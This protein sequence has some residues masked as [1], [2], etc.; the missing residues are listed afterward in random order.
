MVKQDQERHIPCSGKAISLDKNMILVKFKMMMVRLELYPDPFI[1][2]L[3]LWT[4]MKVVKYSA[5]FYKFIM[6]KYLIS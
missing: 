1:R 2:Y 4:I 3:N 6:K 5:L